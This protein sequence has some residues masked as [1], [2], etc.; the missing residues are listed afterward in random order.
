MFGW[1]WALLRRQDDPVDNRRR[2]LICIRL[3]EM[4]RVHPDQITEHCPECGEEVG[5]YPSGQRALREHAGNIDIICN[6]CDHGG[7]GQLA[8]GA[9]L[10]SFQSRWRD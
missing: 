6:H 10:E 3:A 1:F 5:I 7:F 4:L 2:K 8:P 9:E